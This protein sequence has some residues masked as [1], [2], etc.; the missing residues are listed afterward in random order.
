MQIAIP[1]LPMCLK[2]CYKLLESENHF[3]EYN[4]ALTDFGVACLFDTLMKKKK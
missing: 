1:L 4:Y 3:N 2:A